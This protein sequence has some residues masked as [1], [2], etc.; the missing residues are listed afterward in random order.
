[1]FEM[2]VYAA[3]TAT[4]ATHRYVLKTHKFPTQEGCN[5]YVISPDGRGDILQ[6]LVQ[7]GKDDPNYSAFDVRIRPACELIIEA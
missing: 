4:T 1:M 6:L 2:V 3:L 7:L 5:A